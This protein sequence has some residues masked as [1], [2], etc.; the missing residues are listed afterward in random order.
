MNNLLI[1]FALT[2]ISLIL[3]YAAMASL[4]NQ[5]LSA[6]GAAFVLILVASGG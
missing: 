1:F 6:S 2:L 3:L 5:G 4:V